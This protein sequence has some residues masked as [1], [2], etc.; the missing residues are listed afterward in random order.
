MVKLILLGLALLLIMA[1]ALACGEAATPVPTA[2][3]PTATSAPP[4]AAPT[5]APPATEAMMEEEEEETSMTGD[6]DPALVAVADELA[7]GPGSIYI[8]DGNF[9]RLV[10]PAPGVTEKENPDTGAMEQDDPL[11][12]GN[13]MVPLNFI[14]K[15]RHIFETDYYASLLEKAKL[16]DPTPLTSSGEKFNIQYACINRA[17]LPCVLQTVY[18]AETSKNGPTAKLT[19]RYPATRSWVWPVPT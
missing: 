11:G 17:L 19:S 4:T 9:S 13:G 3:P 18:F 5:E 1:F 10:G 16:T 2:V 8:G 14:E 7:G 6:V 12:D 15:N